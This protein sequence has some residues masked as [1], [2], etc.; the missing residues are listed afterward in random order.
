MAAL[1]IREP[2]FDEKS[3][4]VKEMLRICRINYLTLESCAQGDLEALG[5]PQGRCVDVGLINELG[6]NVGNEPDKGQRAN[7]G[8]A[9]A[10]DIGNYSTCFCGCIYCYTS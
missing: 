1:G 8:C 2:A 10:K 6:G 5:V 4:L 3:I 7:C 9:K